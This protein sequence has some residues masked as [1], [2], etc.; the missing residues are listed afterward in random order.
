[1]TKRSLEGFSLAFV[2]FSALVETI[3]DTFLFLDEGD[4]G[5][6][7]V[8]ALNVKVLGTGSSLVGF[9]GKVKGIR[10]WVDW[11]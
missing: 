6:L 10:P 7:K 2:G 4:T 11:F 5:D 9:P 3:S 1:M 8:M